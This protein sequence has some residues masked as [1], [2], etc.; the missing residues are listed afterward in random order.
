MPPEEYLY[1]RSRET[2]F[3]ADESLTLTERQ[4]IPRD[5]EIVNLLRLKYG[6]HAALSLR[7]PAC[8]PPINSRCLTASV[9]FDSLVV[10]CTNHILLVVTYV[11]YDYR[12]VS[13][14]VLSFPFIFSPSVLQRLLF[15]YR[16]QICAS[17]LVTRAFGYQHL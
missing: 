8:E 9:P 17:F 15:R 11:L 6:Q 14:N 2:E 5:T 7:L 13:E 4:R 16:G 1:A 10:G 3:R 12:N